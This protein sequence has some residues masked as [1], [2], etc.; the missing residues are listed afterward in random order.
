MYIIC[1]LMMSTEIRLYL[2]YSRTNISATYYTLMECVVFAKPSS[3]VKVEHEFHK[4]NVVTAQS[5]YKV[6]K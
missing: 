2:N 6:A 3:H 4:T 1:S 5:Q